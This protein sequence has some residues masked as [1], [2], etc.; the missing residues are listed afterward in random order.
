MRSYGKS[1]LL[2]AATVLTLVALTCN[3][4]APTATPVTPLP[5]LPPPIPSPSP[6][7]TQTP[8]LHAAIPMTD[9]PVPLPSPT[10]TPVIPLACPPPGNP[11][12]PE[13]PATFGDYPVVMAVYLSAGGSAQGL[14]RLLRDWGA[15]TD[16]LGK[17]RSLDITGD[18]NPEVIVALTDPMPEFDLPWPPGDVLIFQCQMGSVVPAY[19]GR[20][21]IGLDASDLQFTLDKIEDVNGTG[22]AD[23]VF[24]TSSCGAH[25]CWDRLYIVEWDGAGFVNRVPDMNDYPSATFTVGDS[26]ILV[27]V[28][29][30][31]SVGA[32]Y[33]RSYREEW[34]WDGKQFRMTEQIVGPP[35]ALIHFVH[36]GDDALAQGDYGM[37][38]SHYQSALQDMILPSGLF[39]ETEEQG[40]ALVKAYARF[41]LIVAYAASGDNR[42]A[43][44]QHDRLIA[45]HPD[46]TPGYPYTLLGQTFW[47]NFLANGVPVSA[48]A[49]VVAIAESDP[50]LAERLYAG[51]ANREYEP[52]DLCQLPH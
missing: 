13:R 34:E 41:K 21:T 28:G 35:T 27:A 29:G 25:T 39:V 31:G 37:A 49:V 18:V 10:S 42:G 30:I 11:L 45:E 19:Q 43:Q 14:E 3:R 15:I 12:P 51:Y 2:I 44:S 50:T 26:Q 38:I 17:V 48:C 22:R 20:L 24:V 5:T 1:R 7:A 9:T 36:D 6:T 52:A 32:G 47:N 33:Q 4:T 23:V 46:G 8:T 16:E 40:L